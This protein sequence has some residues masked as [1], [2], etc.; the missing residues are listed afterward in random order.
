MKL[1]VFDGNSM[2]NRAYYAIRGLSTKDGFATNGMYGFL[3]LYEKYFELVSPDMVAVAFDLRAKTFR[4]KM[5]DGYKAQRKGMPD[6]LAAQ[7]EP[8]KEILRAMN[9]CIL[10]KEGYEADDIIGTLAAYAT[11]NGYECY[12]VSGDRDDFQLVSDT[13]TLLLPVTQKGGSETLTVTLDYINEK[14]GLTPAQMIDLKSIMGDSSDNIKGVSGIGE[15]GALDLIQKFGSLDGVYENINSDLIK[16]GVREKL[17]VDREMA[18]L[19]RRLAEICDDVPLDISDEVLSIKPYNQD[20][21]TALLLQYE[22]SSLIKTLGVESA[23][24]AEII[25]YPVLSAS[26]AKEY[27]TQN[28]L[29]F[30]YAIEDGKP[31][32]KMAYKDGVCQIQNFDELLEDDNILKVTYDAKPL[33]KYLILQNKE[34]KKL[35][36]DVMVAQYVLD[37]TLSNYSKESIMMRVLQQEM[38][39]ETSLLPH[40]RRYI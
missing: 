36:F 29:Y 25:E 16:K 14:Y 24:K 6:D 31:T 32:V 4:H 28:G 5:Y 9:V 33:Y 26:E 21:L 38:Q 17:L 23:P 30:Y 20:A 1:L 11:V 3:K 37:S 19:S 18:Y 34:P 7:M 2:I 22:L 35:Y 39:N 15:K 12:I 8:L 40:Y 27:C 10:E 13:T